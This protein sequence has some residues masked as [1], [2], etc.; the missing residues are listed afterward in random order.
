MS[1]P[2]CLIFHQPGVGAGLEEAQ[3]LQ[4]NE[5]GTEHQEA[6]VGNSRKLVSVKEI[7]K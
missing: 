1:W 5:L 6:G 7:Y 3:D 2:I 4:E